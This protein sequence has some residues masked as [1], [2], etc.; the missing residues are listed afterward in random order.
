MGW[1]RRP[2]ERPPMGQPPTQP[3]WT[4]WAVNCLVWRSSTLPPDLGL[5]QRLAEFTTGFPSSCHNTFFPPRGDYSL[6]RLH[7]FSE[8][9]S[10]A[11]RIGSQISKYL[12]TKQVLPYFIVRTYLRKSPLGNLPKHKRKMQTFPQLANE[13]EWIFKSLKCV[14]QNIFSIQKNTWFANYWLDSSHGPEG[15]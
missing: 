9:I 11:Y 1:E 15:V 6:S 8:I 12:P 7:G 14:L 10:R 5:V 13:Q 4:R 2:E 3:L